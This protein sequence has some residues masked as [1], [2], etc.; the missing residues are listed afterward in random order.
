MYRI[1]GLSWKTLQMPPA[2]ID[3]VEFTTA[4][5]EVV[6]GGN[7]TVHPKPYRI[8]DGP[9]TEQFPLFVNT[10]GEPF[11]GKMATYNEHP[12]VGVAIK[13]DRYGQ[14]VGLPR[15]HVSFNPNK[16]AHP[17]EGT[18]DTD[19]MRAQIL[20][21]EADLSE[22][23]IR[24]D[25]AD[26]GLSRID[27]MRQADMEFPYSDHVPILKTFTGRRVKDKTND[28]SYTLE[29]TQRETQWY[30]KGIEQ[31]LENRPSL[32]RCEIRG[33]TGES[34]ERQFGIKTIG[35]LL[36]TD[37]ETLNE[38]YKGH[39][40]Q[41]VFPRHVDAK[42]TFDAPTQMEFADRMMEYFMATHGN[43]GV[44]H[45][46]RTSDAIS[47]VEIY[48]SISAWADRLHTVHGLSRQNAHAWK[49]KMETA[50]AHHRAF[51]KRIESKSARLYDN[52]YSFAI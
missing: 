11:Y 16:F 50:H 46:I 31:N 23:G 25:L 7:F 21:V 9:P 51:L 3:K 38:A 35:D 52:L 30:D 18:T 39:L 34:V 12:R 17:F 24:L 36:K 32:I 20:L 15:L 14:N 42:P 10:Y 8:A 28:T 5:F 27:L 6:G 48:G 22:M 37:I 41:N 29:N 26:M 13:P 43:S 40:L 1:T 44:T 2:S 49:R 33:L 45:W 19:Q 47:I 4:N